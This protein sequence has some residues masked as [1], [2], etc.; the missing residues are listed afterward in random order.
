MEDDIIFGDVRISIPTHPKQDRLREH[1]AQ[2]VDTLAKLEHL[3]D[4]IDYLKNIAL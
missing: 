2:Y 3:K 4:N 1:A